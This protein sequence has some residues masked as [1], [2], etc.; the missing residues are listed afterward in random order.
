[1]MFLRSGESPNPDKELIHESLRTEIERALETLT[2]R[3]ADVI[4][5][6]LDLEIII[7]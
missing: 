7:Q 1:M 3:E 5:F 2:P 4:N 6:I